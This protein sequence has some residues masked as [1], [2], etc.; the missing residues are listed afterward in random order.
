MNYVFCICLALVA[1]LHAPAAGPRD[2]AKAVQGEWKPVKAVLA[3][4]PLSDSLLNV[5]TLK[6]KD[7]AYQ[8]LVGNQPDRGTYTLDSVGTPR[9]MTIT[10]T[11][12]PNNGRKFP[13]IYELKRDTLR[14]CY[15]LAGAKR[16]TEFKS[17]PGTML[18]LVTYNR[19]KR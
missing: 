1:S 13:A 19:V 5:I 3:G 16:P 10:G 14:I 8:V 6:L 15:D 2:D 12:G 7:G 9:G 17:E 4:R 18:Y 11:E